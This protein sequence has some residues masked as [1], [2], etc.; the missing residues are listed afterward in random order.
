MHRPEDGAGSEREGLPGEIL[1]KGF[2]LEIPTDLEV[3]SGPCGPEEVRM[4]VASGGL[5]SKGDTHARRLDFV[6]FPFGPMSHCSGRGADTRVC[7]ADT[8]VGAALYY[9]YSLRAATILCSPPA[10]G[11]AASPNPLAYARGSV[12]ARSYRNCYRAATVR[13]SG[14][15]HRFGRIFRLLR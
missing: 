6:T 2:A 13:E 14:S 9:S 4:V 3:R 8:P 7:S 1:T 10:A 5:T 15:G 12:G 11:I